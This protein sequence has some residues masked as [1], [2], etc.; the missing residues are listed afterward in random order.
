MKRFALIG[1]ALLLT[2]CVEDYKSPWPDSLQLLSVNA[3]YPAGYA[4]AV[5]EG[6]R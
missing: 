5:H 2:A 3:V 4:H 1:L 6:A